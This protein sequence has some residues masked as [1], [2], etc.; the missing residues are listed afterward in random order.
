MNVTYDSNARLHIKITDGT[1]RFE[2]PLEIGTAGPATANRL[3]NVEINEDPAT[4]FF[5]KVV[6]KEGSVTLFDTS[7]GGF[8]FSD[9]F[10]QFTTKLPSKNLYGIGEVEQHSFR[11]SFEGYPNWPLFGRDQPPDV[12]PLSNA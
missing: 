6:R 10:L 2:V 5:F 4:P 1:P 11:H 8:T 7:L 12:S 3:Y 9:Q